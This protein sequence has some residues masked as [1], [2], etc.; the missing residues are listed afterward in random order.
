MKPIAIA[1]EVDIA[2]EL[3]MKWSNL[4]KNHIK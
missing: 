2:L 4:K 3:S 1:L